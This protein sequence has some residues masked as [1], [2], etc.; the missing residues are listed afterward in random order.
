MVGEEKDVKME[1]EWRLRNL[2]F[3]PPFLKEHFCFY[4]YHF[5]ISFFFHLCHTITSP[6]LII[7]SSVFLVTIQ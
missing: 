1:C 6:F 2:L 3:Y 7:Y 5:L 4:S